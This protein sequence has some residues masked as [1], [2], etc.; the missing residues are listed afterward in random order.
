MP[1]EY[2]LQKLKQDRE[3]GYKNI[4]L[5]RVLEAEALPGLKPGEWQKCKDIPVGISGEPNQM[6]LLPEGKEG[7][8]DVISG[9]PAGPFTAKN[10]TIGGGIKI[11]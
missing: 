9:I 11:V 3:P 5:S 6:A 7:K 1:W 10:T 4:E 8:Y 2:I